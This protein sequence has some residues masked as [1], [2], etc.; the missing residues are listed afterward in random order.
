M[1]GHPESW[2]WSAIWGRKVCLQGEVCKGDRET[3]HPDS[4]T[5]HKSDWEGHQCHLQR[6]AWCCGYVH[7]L[8]KA[9][10]QPKR[11]DYILNVYSKTGG[12]IGLFTGLSLI[13]FVEIMYWAIKVW[14]CAIDVLWTYWGI[15]FSSLASLK[16]CEEDLNAL[17]SWWTKVYKILTSKIYDSLFE[18]DIQ[19]E[20][21]QTNILPLKP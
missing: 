20:M 6:Q 8:K 21:Q 17:T 18:F 1:Q 19:T 9:L 7:L 5:K 3:D 12:T 13:S 14:F 16:P 11:F 10:Y 4:W 15:L 2:I